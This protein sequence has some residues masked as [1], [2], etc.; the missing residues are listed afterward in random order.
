MCNCISLKSFK[1]RNSILTVEQP[2]AT[3]NAMTASC[4]NLRNLR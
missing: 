3:S 2:N 1:F 4:A